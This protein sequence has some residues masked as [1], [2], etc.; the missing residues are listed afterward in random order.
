L[1]PAEPRGAGRA[2]LGVARSGAGAAALHP[3]RSV[4]TVLCVVSLVLPWLVG[5]GISRGLRDALEEAVALGPDLVVTGT[6]FGRPVPLP[7]EAAARVAAVP[8]VAAALPRVVGEARL[9]AEGEPA[10]VVGL[11]AEAVPPTVRFLEGRLFA[12]GAEGEIVVGSALARRLG[13][14]VGAVVPPFYRNEA[15]ERTSTVVGVFDADA[16]LGQ[17]HLVLASLETARRI[18][19]E[20]EASTDL[21]VRCAEPLREPVARRIRSLGTLGPDGEGPPVRARVSTRDDAAALLLRRALDRETLLQLPF[22]LAFAVG[23]PL[24]LVTSGAG[25]VERRRE[26]GLLRAVGWS[27]DAL[28][29]RALAESA[30]L[31][32]AGAAIAVLGAALWLGLLDGAGL[33]PVLLP[34]AARVPGFRVPW[35]L[36]P[37]PALLAAAVSAVLVAAGTLH[38][39]WRAA[40]AAPA[41]AMR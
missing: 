39:T 33:A 16:P 27:A 29:L 37:E 11:P 40:S 32:A 38:S 4:V 2:L 19:A 8:G 5:E 41:E 28:L 15:G 10:V 6:R 9:G 24:V 1:S 31:A 18:F 17:A 30:L 35:N 22:V 13:I 21:L 12:P 20:T 23:I 14:R 26:A 3:L 7:A 25:L 34:G 36:G